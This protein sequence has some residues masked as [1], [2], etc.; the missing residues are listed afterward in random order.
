MPNCGNGGTEVRTLQG[1]RGIECDAIR[2]GQREA[3]IRAAYVA[4]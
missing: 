4:D 2:V 1:H 3:R